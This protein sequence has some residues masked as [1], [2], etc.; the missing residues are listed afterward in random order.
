MF[1]TP[2]LSGGFDLIVCRQVM[3]HVTDPI[4]FLQGI[5]GGLVE[6]GRAYIEVPSMSY[7]DTFAAPMDFHYP[8]VQYY[9]PHILEYL[10][11][12]TGFSVVKSIAIKGGH[13]MGYVIQRDLHVSPLPLPKP[14]GD[15]V[16]LRRRLSARVAIG[17][18]KLSRIDG[19]IGAY[20]VS[21]CTECL[22][23]MYG[24]IINFNVGLDDTSSYH[25]RLTYSLDQAIPILP[26]SP[27]ILRKLDAVV[28][29]TYMHDQVISHKLR[30]N[31]FTG[32]IFSGRCDDDAGKTDSPPSLF[33]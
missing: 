15:P 23:G 6:G 32:L 22:F 17:A 5:H 33:V 8:H 28:I 21:A 31:G 18:E 13:D 10:F 25:G 16:K 1:P 26:P 14:M 30:G 27:N 2:Q 3:E 4:T 29:A 24:N 12:L 7:L 19:P 20:G 11:H 9:Y